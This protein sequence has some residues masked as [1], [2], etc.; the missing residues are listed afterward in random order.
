VFDVAVV[1]GGIVGLATARELLSRNPRQR[2]LVLEKE[3]ELAAHQSGHNSGV[4]HSG[5]YY[6][7]GS[8]KARNCRR[9]VG[10]LVAFCDE[11]DVPYELCGKVIVAV[12]DEE[13]PRLR[14]LYQRG[15]ENGVG[16][17]RL[18]SREELK[19]IEPHAEGVEA[20]VSAETGI[21][22][23]GA[24][25][26]K[27]GE[28]FLSE[29]GRI[30]TEAEVLSLD[31]D[32]LVTTAGEFEAKRVVCCAGLHADRVA[33]RLG[34]R[35]SMLVLG[36]RGEYYRL[37]PE[38]RHLVRHLIYPVPDPRFPFLGVHFTR[39]ITGQIDAGPNAVLAFAREGYEKSD[40]DWRDVKEMLG[41]GGFWRM[42]A[43]H[44]SMAFDEYRRSI[45]KG[46]FVR[47]LKRL[48]PEITAA[49]LETGGTGVRAVALGRDG[50]LIDDFRIERSGKVV[51]VLNAPSPAA[52]SAL[53]I[54][55]NVADLIE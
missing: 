33:T 19:E 21:V 40:V 25:A 27:L 9:G 42:G 49:D 53:A 7:P 13:G 24:V 2:I 10:K 26:A 15:R 6:R 55:E 23:F 22:D 29:G 43:K 45:S 3:R 54:A 38:S 36:F 44:W 37:R 47:G 12:S 8:S 39:R 16:G 17:L 14:A 31:T 46:A 30:E 28:V 20:L 32:T 48:V 4:I 5:I 51:N 1:G 18:I 50:E 41:F 52:T 11:H 34:A 35:P